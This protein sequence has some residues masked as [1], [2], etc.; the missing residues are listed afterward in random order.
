MVFAGPALDTAQR[1]A[2]SSTPTR[3]VRCANGERRAESPVG[4]P[5]QAKALQRPERRRRGYPGK[6]NPA[7]RMPAL[8]RERP[9]K[10]AFCCNPL[11]AV[12]APLFCQKRYADRCYDMPAFDRA[13]DLFLQVFTVITAVGCFVLPR[14]ISWK[15]LCASFLAARLWAVLFPPGILA[16][17]KRT[18]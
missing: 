17:Q 15:L 14:T 11:A 6:G 2:G 10:T 3:P 9:P 7:G 13:I 8:Q 18:S 4:M 5:L 16:W 12:A 1:P